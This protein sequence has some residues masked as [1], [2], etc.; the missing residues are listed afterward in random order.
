MTN[1]KPWTLLFLTGALLAGC[2]EDLYNPANE[3]EE[4]EQLPP[5]EYYFSFNTRAEVNLYVNYAYPGHETLIEVFDLN[6]VVT[7]G[8]VRTKRTDIEP[9]FKAFTD[10]KGVFS[11]KMK[12]PTTTTS[13]YLYTREIGLPECVELTC[14]GDTYS[15]DV[16]ALPV[17]EPDEA[18]T[19][20][21][22]FSGNAPYQLKSTGLYSLFKWQ[23]TVRIN[24]RRQNG[25][26]RLYTTDYTIL[27]NVKGEG[28]ASFTSR[29]KSILWNKMSSKPSD[30]NNSVLVSDEVEKTNFYLAVPTKVDLMFLHERA[31]YRNAFGYYYYKGYGDVDPSSLRKFVIFPNVSVIGDDPYASTT[32]PILTSGQQ[33]RLLFFGENGDQAGTEEFPAGYTIGW[34]M[35]SN[36]FN[37]STNEISV[38]SSNL[39][40]SNDPVSKRGF[41]SVYDEALKGVIVGAE[42]GG[43]Q[44]YEDLLFCVFTDQ[45]DAIIDPKN[46]GRPTIKKGEDV[47]T[48]PEV[49]GIKGTLA[50]EDIWPTGGDYDLNDVVVEYEQHVTFDSKNMVKQIEDVFRPVHNGASYHNAFAYQ[51][52]YGQIGTLTLPEGSLYEQETQSIIVFPNQQ[53]AIGKSYTIKRTF[54]E[55]AQF[56]KSDLSDYNPYIIVNYVAGAANRTEVHLPK[57]LSTTLADQSLNYTQDDAYFIDKAGQ[58]PF[59]IDLPITG[60]TPAAETARIDSNDQY[61]DFKPW[62]ESKGTT[63][64]DWYNHYKGR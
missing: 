36:G 32:S 2:T 35:V 23:N 26:G 50:Y 59:A 37:N 49:T 46:P 33:V 43:D 27:D 10:L 44:S 40:T 34:F 55:S 25:E 1:A 52:S 14:E 63:N 7:T 53:Q 48:L 5:Q 4:Q 64:Q 9:L 18:T 54:S 61:P 30:L 24:G 60:F 12:I 51:L 45:M 16:S 17:A 47:I 11:G 6:P 19:R 22:S 20:S 28:I 39:L 15:F 38:T 21:Y 41:I 29:L 56:P 57:M 13:L 3:K 8:N 31:G 62:A 58:Y 42:D